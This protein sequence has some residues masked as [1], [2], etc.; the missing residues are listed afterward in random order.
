MNFSLFL[1][2]DYSILAREDRIGMT[3]N[4]I[5]HQLCPIEDWIDK[6]IEKSHKIY[7]GQV[8]SIDDMTKSAQIEFYYEGVC[9]RKLTGET[10][11]PLFLFEHFPQEGDEVDYHK[12]RLRASEVALVRIKSEREKRK[13]LL[14]EILDK[15]Q[16]AYVNSEKVL[17]SKD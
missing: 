5:L 17:A 14:K 8:L 11:V 13:P 4:K 16:I 6:A 7:Q 2:L 12:M 15:N 9:G 10:E 1:Y 3:G